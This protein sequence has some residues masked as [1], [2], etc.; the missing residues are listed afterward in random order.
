MHETWTWLIPPLAGAALGL[1]FFGGLWW[2]TRRAAT[3]RH[4]GLYLLCSAVL[5][6][7][8]TLLGFY[9]AGGGRWERW[10]L[11]LA[12]FLLA[13]GAVTWRFGRAH[14]GVWRAQPG[15]RHAP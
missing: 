15:A 13:R 5:R 2:T 14:R 3:F 8:L 12:G 7:G 1:M 9:L 4:P 10:L 6:M 11:C